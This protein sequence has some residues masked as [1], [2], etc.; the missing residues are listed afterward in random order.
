MLL[1]LTRTVGSTGNFE[2]AFEWLCKKR[3]NYSPFADVWELRYQWNTEMPQIQQAILS[4]T[5]TFD[6]IRQHRLPDGSIRY[7]W[8]ARDA[9]VLR[10][11][12]QVLTDFL[13]PKLGATHHLKGNGGIAGALKF[14]NKNLNANKFV[15]KT[16]IKSYYQ[17][18]PHN[19][20]M[21]E[22]EELIPD[23]KL[24]ALVEQTIRRTETYGEIYWDIKKGIPQGSSLSPLLGAVA[25]LC[26]DRAMKKAGL[27]YA[28]YMDDLIVLTKTKSQ[29]RRAIKI[30]YKTLMKWK[31]KLHTNEKTFI[32]KISKGFDYCGLHLNYK[33]VTLSE[34]CVSKFMNN[35]SGLYEQAQRKSQ[36]TFYKS[37]PDF[38]AV[39]QYIQ[40]FLRW[41]EWIQNNTRLGLDQKATYTT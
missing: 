38:S 11:I 32:G 1:L 20:L 22:L 15:F 17:S 35:I 39:S 4:G 30:T 24:L 26:W 3:K 25:L 33:K 12:T 5:Y 21:L 37:K 9:L 6:A 34:S 41:S 31:Y 27:V 36:A 2:K 14:V 16:D 40:R 23:K 13:L 19:Q 10:S 7:I 29:L 8:A 18:I 28:R